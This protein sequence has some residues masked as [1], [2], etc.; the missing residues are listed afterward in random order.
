[1][2][3]FKLKQASAALGVPPK[4]LQ[5]LVQLGV[6]R[7]LR[8]GGVRWFDFNLLL[9]AKTAFYLRDSLGTSSELLARICA[10]L[11]REF[12]Q[13]ASRTEVPRFRDV[14]LRSRPQH[15][16]E[17]VEIRVPLRA[18][19]R[20][21]QQQLPQARNVPDLPRGRKRP[22]WKKELLRA[23]EQASGAL[24]GV[25]E[26]RIQDAIRQYRSARK[27]LPEIA[28]VAPTKDKTA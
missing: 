11:A 18:L 2:E 9:Q 28:I 24:A 14:T 27:K 10:A 17:A 15:S 7:P 19:A 21:L 6:L 12:E 26:E 16:R 8:R 23:L 4:D 5:N 20:E 22:G 1:M 3:R 25:S 13:A